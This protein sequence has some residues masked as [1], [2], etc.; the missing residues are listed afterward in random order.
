MEEGAKEAFCLLLFISNGGRV[1]DKGRPVFARGVA[2]R[3]LCAEPV[4]CYQ[5]SLMQQEIARHPPG[6]AFWVCPACLTQVVKKA[7]KDGVPH[8]VTGHYTE[9]HC[10]YVGCE[11]PPRQEG[12]E[13]LARGYSRFLQLFIGDVNY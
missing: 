1:D 2:A 7:K 8:H 4:D 6:H 12:N 9:G 5:C 10:Q 3:G 13:E 11:R